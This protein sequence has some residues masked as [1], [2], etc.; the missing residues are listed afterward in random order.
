MICDPENNNT[1]NLVWNIKKE[2][3]RKLSSSEAY[4]FPMQIF[5]ASHFHLNGM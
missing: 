4:F 1:G 5:L 3:W 2:G